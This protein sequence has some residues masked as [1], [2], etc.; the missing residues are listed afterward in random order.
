MTLAEP[1]PFQPPTTTELLQSAGAGD[2]CAWEQ[3]VRRFEP[4]V[5]A[6]VSSFR[7]QDADARDA[8]QRTWL[9]MIEYHGQVREPEA[10]AGWLKTTARRECLRIVRDQRRT[11]PLDGM[12]GA[13]CTDVSI[14]IEQ[15]VI[16]ADTKRQLGQLIRR[17]PQRSSALL[18]LLFQEDPPCYAELSRKTGIPVGSIGPTRARALIQLR[19]LIAAQAGASRKPGCRA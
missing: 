17:L 10:L 4:A 13:E 14:D 12:E 7:L 5:A 19:R 6:M 2:Q 1:K 9:Q 15:R 18:G 8:A 16:D 11:E 3:L